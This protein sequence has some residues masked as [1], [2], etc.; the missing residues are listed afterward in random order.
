MERVLS[1]VRSHG[2]AQK[3]LVGAAV[4]VVALAV[5]APLVVLVNLSGDCTYTRSSATTDEGSLETSAKDRSESRATCT[6]DESSLSG[7]DTTSI[8]IVVIVAAIVVVVVAIAATYTIVKIGVTVSLGDEWS[9]H[10]SDQDGTY[11]PAV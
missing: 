5:V 6:A 7:A 4:A 2:S 9:G 10:G 11:N 3:S 1:A 8:A